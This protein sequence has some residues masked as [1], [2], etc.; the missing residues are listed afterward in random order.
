[1]QVKLNPAGRGD[2][3]VPGISL[4][5]LEPGPHYAYTSLLARTSTHLSTRSTS[6]W[7]T[8]L[9]V[10]WDEVQRVWRK[11]RVAETYIV[12]F[13]QF[14]PQI[15]SLLCKNWQNT[16]GTQFFTV[17]RFNL[18][19]RKNRQFI[20]TKCVA[21][22]LMCQQKFGIL[23][24]ERPPCPVSDLTRQPVVFITQLGPP[25]SLSLTIN[26]SANAMVVHL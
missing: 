16:K 11:G 9:S 3:L 22:K 5:S 26:K 10:S 4:L 1:M 25:L 15:L 23:P 14:C 7:H 18:R 21:R 12:H 20:S 24:S 8:G 2:C 6:S 19:I 17:S 13:R